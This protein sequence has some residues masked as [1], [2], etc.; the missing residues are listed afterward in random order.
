[1]IQG[2]AS[3]PLRISLLT[4]WPSLRYFRFIFAHAVRSRSGRDRP[5][6]PA[7]HE[8]T[9]RLQVARAAPRRPEGAHRAGAVPS[10]AAEAG[11][12]VPGWAARRQ[13]D[14]ANVVPEVRP[15]LRAAGGVVANGNGLLPRRPE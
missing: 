6:N 7:R 5:R 9:R 1:M 12:R 3:T 2:S 14:Q 13:E 15:S 4:R 8:G 11:V 10:P